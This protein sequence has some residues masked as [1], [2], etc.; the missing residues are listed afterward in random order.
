M[1]N[2][3]DPQTD[4]YLLPGSAARPPSLSSA[5][6]TLNSRK[7]GH[8]GLRWSYLNTECPLE[9]RVTTHDIDEVR[10]SMSFGREILSV[11]YGCTALACSNL[12]EEG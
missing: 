12:T 10:G 1:K 6:H 4:P 9:T 7:G 2:S 11:Y 5:A 3:H 8:M